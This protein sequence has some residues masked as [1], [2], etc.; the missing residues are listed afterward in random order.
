MVDEVAILILFLFDETF[1]ISYKKKS[2]FL[3][4]PKLLV[5][6]I[7]FPCFS[8]FIHACIVPKALVLSIHI[9]L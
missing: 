3:G 5:R 4:Y 7:D 1:F 2:Q 6:F 8:M 9:L